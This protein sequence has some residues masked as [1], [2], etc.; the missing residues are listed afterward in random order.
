MNFLEQLAAEWYE[1]SG[2]FV[3]T[4]LRFGVNFDGHGGAQR[5][6]GCNCL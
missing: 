2:Y 5:R 3:R 4:N 6:N 1:D